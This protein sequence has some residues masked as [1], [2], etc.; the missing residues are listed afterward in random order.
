MQCIFKYIITK[1]YRCLHI[2]NMVAGKHI[3]LNNKCVS[4]FIVVRCDSC[5]EINMIL[6]SQ[7]GQNLLLLYV[8]NMDIKCI[9]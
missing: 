5:T 6:F 9:L 8:E 1:L 2:R 4:P 7:L 3:E